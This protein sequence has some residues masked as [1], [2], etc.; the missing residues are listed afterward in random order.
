[1]AR[2]MEQRHTFVQYGSGYAHH[3]AYGNASSSVEK[4]LLKSL[5]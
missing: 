2:I 1:M 4:K 3:T 5:L